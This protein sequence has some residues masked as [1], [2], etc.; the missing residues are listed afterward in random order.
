[1]NQRINTPPCLT[2]TPIQNKYL[3]DWEHRFF[4]IPAGR[5]SRKTLIGKQKVLDRALIKCGNYFLGAPTYSQAKAIFWPDMKKYTSFFQKSKSETD[6]TIELVNGSIIKVLGLDKP[7]RVEGT[8]WNGC[9]ITETGNVKETAWSE[10]IRPVLSDTMGFAMLD[11]VPEGRNWYYEKALYACG[12]AIPDTVPFHGAF[13]E[14]VVDDDSWAYYHWFSSDVLNASEIAAAK[15]ELDERTFRQEYE[16]SFESYEGLAY[17]AF[18]PHNISSAVRY[19]NTD[20]VH[21]GMDFNVDPMTAVFCHVLN[22]NIEQFDEAYLRHAN[23]YEMV[24]HIKSKYAITNCIVY[25]DSTGRAERSNATESDIAI[26]RRAGFKVRARSQ[27]PQQRDR[28][29]AVNSMLLTTTKTVRYK[30]HPDCRCTIN[31]FNRVECLPDGRLNKDQEKEGLVHTTDGLGYL[32]SYLF[33]V[34]K[35]EAYGKLG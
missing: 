31:D 7:E 35:I 18:S 22:N 4:V 11:G 29:N 24:E 5:R 8:P 6:L 2:L 10:H 32:I 12:G 23:T 1:M 13:A 20:V 21:I 17:W 28:L 9:L 14:S 27:N 16:G 33:P 30:V 25:P 26:L 3:N 15:R 34:R 19:N